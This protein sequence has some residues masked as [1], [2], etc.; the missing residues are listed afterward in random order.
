MP[1]PG[2]TD[3]ATGGRAGEA[4][5]RSRRGMLELELLLLPF[6]ESTYARL[7]PA[8]QDAYHRLLGKE[9]WEI[10]DWLRGIDEPGDPA[11]RHIVEEIRK[12][13]E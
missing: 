2:P 4:Y 7:T 10:F 3:D 5:W 13:A 12:R 9:D 6:V 11:L 8:L 1:D